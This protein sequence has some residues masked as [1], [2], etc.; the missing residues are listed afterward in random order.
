MENN[1]SKVFRTF[2]QR[3]KVLTGLAS[4]GYVRATPVLPEAYA[5]EP[6]TVYL[7]TKFCRDY[8]PGIIYICNEIDGKRMWM[9][10][11]IA[12]LGHLPKPTDFWKRIT[13]DAIILHWESP[14]D[15][16]DPEN[17]WNNATW[18]YEVIVRKFGT[19]RSSVTPPSGISTTMGL[20]DSSFLL[21]RMILTTTITTLCS[22]A[23]EAMCTHDLMSL[24]EA[25]LGQRSKSRLTLELTSVHSG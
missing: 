21:M 10:I 22:L 18:D 3:D 11:S 8:V 12:E 9:D 1:L 13:K 23:Q 2:E 4:K 15:V 19:V 25:G 24:G 5:T 20:T 14:E 17:S 6:G 16:V 7:L